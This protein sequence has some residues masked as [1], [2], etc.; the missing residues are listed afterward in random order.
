MAWGQTPN[1]DHSRLF[2]LSLKMKCAIYRW[3]KMY[4]SSLCSP[5]RSHVSESIPPQTLNRSGLFPS[6]CSLSTLASASAIAIAELRFAILA[7]CRTRRATMWIST[8]PGSGTHIS[9]TPLPKS[10]LSGLQITEPP[11][12]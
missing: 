3:C 10:L 8:S 5:N 7:S 2:H 11:N 1:S 6:S 12:P 9:L 4:S